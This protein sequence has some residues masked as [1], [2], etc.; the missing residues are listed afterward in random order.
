MISLLKEILSRTECSDFDPRSK[1]LIIAALRY[2]IAY[3]LNLDFGTIDQSFISP[4]AVCFQFVITAMAMRIRNKRRKNARSIT[5]D[6]QSQFNKAQIDTHFYAVKF[7]EGLK[8]PSKKELRRY[9]THP[10][11][12]GL[13]KDLIL[14]KGVPKEKIKVWA[15]EENIGL[16]I[17]DI[18]LWIVNR[19]LLG[20]ELSEELKALAF[21]FLR[22]SMIDGISMESMAQRW[23]KFEAELPLIE[24]LTEEQIAYTR[25]MVEK[26]RAKIAEL[27]I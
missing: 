12:H 8:S 2:G 7:R 9:I 19:Y 16:Q 4:N 14:Y 13:D 18:Y 11:Y 25:Q 24:D 6:R 20:N 3:P 1:E 21:S 27:N 23:E 17:V 15:S 5:V 26:H 10:M 22:R